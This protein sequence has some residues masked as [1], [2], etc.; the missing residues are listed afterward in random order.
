MALPYLWGKC[1][2]LPVNMDGWTDEEKQLVT[3]LQPLYCNEE[4]HYNELASLYLAD[5]DTAIRQLFHFREIG[6]HSESTFSSAPLFIYFILYICMACLV[7]NTATPA[8]M[9]VPS[10]LSGAAFGR[11][12]G[13]LLHKLDNTR[14]TFADSGTYALMGAASITAG[15]YLT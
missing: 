9:F 11:L 12:F 14:G 8:G 10:L 5:S 13:H 2:S 7:C 3:N 6:D 15:L 4:T 1:T